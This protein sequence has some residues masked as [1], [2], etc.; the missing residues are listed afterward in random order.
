MIFTMMPINYQWL[1]LSL[2]NSSEADTPSITHENNADL[3]KTAG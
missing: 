2:G 1:R 3:Y